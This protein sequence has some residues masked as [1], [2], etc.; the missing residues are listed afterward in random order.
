MAP[1]KLLERLAVRL[2]KVLGDRSS[3]NHFLIELTIQ[4]M[5]WKGQ[6][7]REAHL[8]DRVKLLKRVGFLAYQLLA[9]LAQQRYVPISGSSGFMG[10]KSARHSSS[11]QAEDYE[12][13]DLSLAR[14]EATLYR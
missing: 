7:N 14:L 6:P 5:A 12:L 9:C 4:A 1:D 2:L 13:A 11:R 8:Q 10:R 3:P